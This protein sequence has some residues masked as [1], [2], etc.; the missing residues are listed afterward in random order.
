MRIFV[1]GA[2]GLVGRRLV[3]DRRERGDHVVVLSRNGARA[4]EVLAAA[5]VEGLEVVEGDPSAGGAWRQHLD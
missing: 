1:T 3:A 2:T 4:R 5:S